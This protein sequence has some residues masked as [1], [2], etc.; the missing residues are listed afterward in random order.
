MVTSVAAITILG[1]GCS[2]I[3]KKLDKDPQ[4]AF[5]LLNAKP[6]SIK[7]VITAGQQILSAYDARL[8]SAQNVRRRVN[9]GIIAT[10]LYTAI[11]AGTGAHMHN[12]VTST[13]IGGA[14]KLIEPNLQ[15]EGSPESLGSAA[16]KTVCVL[17][18]ADPVLN[19]SQ[20]FDVLKKAKSET[21]TDASLK[22]KITLTSFKYNNVK[23]SV[24]NSILTIY[25]DQ[26]SS[27]TPALVDHAAIV[28]VLS[29]GQN[30]ETGT[31]NL[32]NKKAIDTL[33]GAALDS[34]LE[35]INTRVDQTLD[36]AIAA[37]KNCT[38]S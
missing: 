1:S 30:N 37:I 21:T 27:S 29:A 24:W 13:A 20:S 32:K 2:S 6:N 34:K 7:D 5:D 16:V 4:S 18:A 22:G 28:T 14:L 11:A 31:G 25:F 33:E 35:E 17:R 23:S 12:I 38:T 26:S 36:I 19:I 15:S 8:S 3:G 9:L 10:G